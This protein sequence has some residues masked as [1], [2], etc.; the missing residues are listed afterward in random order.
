MEEYGGRDAVSG[1][2]GLRRT[3]SSLVAFPPDWMHVTHSKEFPAR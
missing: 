2:T 1:R 3:G